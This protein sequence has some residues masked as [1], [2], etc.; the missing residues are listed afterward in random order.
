MRR[1]KK[2]NLLCACVLVISAVASI[3]VSAGMAKRKVTPVTRHGTAETVATTQAVNQQEDKN[4]KGKSNQPVG[5]SYSTPTKVEFPVTWQ[6]VNDDGSLDPASLIKSKI[7][8]SFYSYPGTPPRDDGFVFYKR[9][10]ENHILSTREESLHSYYL[11]TGWEYSGGNPNQLVTYGAYN[12][13]VDK[14]VDEPVEGLELVKY[15]IRH[16][17]RNIRVKN[18]AGAEEDLP[19]FDATQ[20]A[21]MQHNKLIGTL[22]GGTTEVIATNVAITSTETEIT[23]PTPKQYTKL[24]FIFDTPIKFMAPTTTT[25]WPSYGE[26]V[27]IKYSFKL[28]ENSYNTVKNTLSTMPPIYYPV[29]F[30]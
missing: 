12:H 16:D 15:A 13:T 11:S 5:T 26:G 8:D 4:S 3:S 27:S 6:F 7:V 28:T 1:I 25:P 30:F 21:N 14:I 17:G 20:I 18:A 9:G 29:R 2:Y 22:P 19:V 23:L 24:E 10:Y